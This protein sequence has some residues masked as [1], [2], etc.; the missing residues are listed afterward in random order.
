MGKNKPPFPEPEESS[1]ES[2]SDLDIGDFA[3]YVSSLPESGDDKE[4]YLRGY[5]SF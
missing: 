5:G 4:K 1:D 2:G 3:Q